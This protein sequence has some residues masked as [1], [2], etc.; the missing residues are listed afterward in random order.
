[1]LIVEILRHLLQGSPDFADA[2]I[3]E[4]KVELSEKE[5]QNA[6]EELK[7]K[8]DVKDERWWA[9]ALRDKSLESIKAALALEK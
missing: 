4:L 7:A 2:P 1:M 3:D 5:L 9:H 8:D 6:V